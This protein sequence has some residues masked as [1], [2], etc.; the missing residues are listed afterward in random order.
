MVRPKTKFPD[1][2]AEPKPASI[3]SS[4]PKK[5]PRRRYGGLA[6]D[7]D[8]KEGA[9]P[10]SPSLYRSIC[11]QGQTLTNVSRFSATQ[12]A[13]VPQA[14]HRFSFLLREASVR[15]RGR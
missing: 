10:D 3:S 12:R 13:R 2:E 7:Q 4:F 9:R 6:R 15:R 8:K 5:L 1:C 14:T 11:R